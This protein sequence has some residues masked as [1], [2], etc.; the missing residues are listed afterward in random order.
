MAFPLPVFPS[1]RPI[2]RLLA[3]AFFLT[4]LLVPAMAW[5]AESRGSVPAHGPR[6]LTW[7]DWVVIVTYMVGVLY[8]GAY[9]ASSPSDLRRKVRIR[10]WNPA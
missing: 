4:W 6:G 5:A 8:L 7:I 10:S 9:V 1:A 2:S 3:L